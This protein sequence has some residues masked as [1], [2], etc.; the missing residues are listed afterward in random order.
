ML[1][2]DNQIREVNKEHPNDINQSVLE[3]SNLMKIMKQAHTLENNLELS[4]MNSKEKN[5]KNDN[6]DTKL[7]NDDN[8]DINYSDYFEI[9]KKSLKIGVDF[10]IIMMLESIRVLLVFI[11]CRN[12]GIVYAETIGA[13]SLIYDMICVDLPWALS[14][15]YLYSGSEAYSSNNGKLLGILSNKM[16]F[17]LFILG[18]F[19]SIMCCIIINPIYSV[20]SD[21]SLM[22]ENLTGIMRYMSIGT[23]FWFMA[24]CGVRYLGIIEKSF[25]GIVFCAV[26]IIAQIIWLLIFVVGFDSIIFG[27]GF[28]FSV[29]FIVNYISQIIYIYWYKPHPESAINIFKGIFT[30]FWQF[31]IDST[32]IGITVYINY[33]TIDFLPYLALIVSD[34]DYTMANILIILIIAFNLGSEG[35]NIG[36]N[37]MIN[38]IIGRKNYNYI[39]NMFLV[40]SVFNFVYAIIFGGLFSVFLDQIMYLYVNDDTFSEKA[41]TYKVQF[42]FSLLISSYHNILSETVLVCGGE[43]WGLVSI[44]VG[45]LFVNY[46]L[47]LG[48]IYFGFDCVTSLLLSFII[49][50][51]VTL[52]MNGCYLGYI[53]K[54]KNKQLNI[55]MLLLSTRYDGINANISTSNNNLSN[56]KN[57]CENE[58]A[59]SDLAEK[60]DYNDNEEKYQDFSSNYNGSS[61]QENVATN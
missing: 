43:A 46:S 19:F 13:M 32:F 58:N 38:Y 24:Q 33:F 9:G 20:I 21:E 34:K 22:V 50:Q 18:V 49:G 10:Y 53:F 5:N 44:L 12:K 59:I 26:S 7:S 37:T 36:N 39:F 31:I 14:T 2:E 15:L 35:L 61:F 56:T 3:N 8:L 16:N 54:N 47:G 45:R 40:S 42:F 52:I 6:K 48:F 57:R 25:Y 17:Y 28:S 60:F 30:N 23:P 27:I 55:N 29:A 4:S 11:V 51:S 41:G 1:N